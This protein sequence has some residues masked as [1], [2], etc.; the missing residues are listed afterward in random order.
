[1]HYQDSIVAQTQQTLPSRA[2]DYSRPPM[3]Y[4]LRRR[5]AVTT[6]YIY[7]IS[8]HQKSTYF[9]TSSLDNPNNLKRK[10][11]GKLC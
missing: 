1:M 6:N 10:A 4:L 3:S 2:E 5:N 11:R 8:N 9:S 7:T